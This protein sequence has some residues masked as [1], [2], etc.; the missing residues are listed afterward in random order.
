[1]SEYGQISKIAEKI[2][3]LESTKMW[4]WIGIIASLLSG[5]IAI[6]SINKYISELKDK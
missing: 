3:E 6:R 2:K 4:A 5:L 1:M